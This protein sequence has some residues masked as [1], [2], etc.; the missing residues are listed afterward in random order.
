MYLGC[1]HT[2]SIL[3]SILAAAR[4]I[5]GAFRL[6]QGAI[7]LECAGFEAAQMR[8]VEDHEE[9]GRG[10]LVWTVAEI[11]VRENGRSLEIKDWT[12]L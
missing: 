10:D 9:P 11:V 12:C 8:M 2:R 5:G 6:V 3:R 7:L 4:E 1:R